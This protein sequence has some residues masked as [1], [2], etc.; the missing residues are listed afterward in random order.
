MKKE[1]MKE[2]MKKMDE[3]GNMNA[4]KK[5]SIDEKHK[6][7]HNEMMKKEGGPG[8]GPQK[9]TTDK[10][11]PGAGTRAGSAPDGGQTDKEHDDYEDEEYI[12]LTE[13]ENINQRGR[14]LSVHP[15]P[16]SPAQTPVFPEHL[17]SSSALIKS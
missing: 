3:Y 17:A 16:S 5:E 1:M 14:P 6:P 15:L 10:M 13:E 4:M 9:G 7:G 2:I 12:E 11:K 8:S